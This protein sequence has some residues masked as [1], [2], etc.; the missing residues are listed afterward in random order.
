MPNPIGWH[1]TDEAPQTPRKSRAERWAKG[2]TLKETGPRDWPIVTFALSPEN[3]DHLAAMSVLA[4]MGAGDYLD[5]LVTGDRLA[6][7]GTV[8]TVRDWFHERS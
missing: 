7:G 1:D 4:G 6:N 8:D 5:S 2:L 3:Y